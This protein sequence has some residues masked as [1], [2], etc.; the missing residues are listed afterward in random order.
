MERERR[1][2]RREKKNRKKE[3]KR[4]EKSGGCDQHACYILHKHDYT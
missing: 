2:G 4:E 1:D 3:G